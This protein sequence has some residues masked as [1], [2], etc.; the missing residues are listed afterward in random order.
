MS[1]AATKV[2]LKEQD[3]DA[4]YTPIAPNYSFLFNIEKKLILYLM[5]NKMEVIPVPIQN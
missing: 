1:T 5:T 3:Q 2:N 4:K